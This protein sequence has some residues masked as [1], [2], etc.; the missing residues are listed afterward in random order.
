VHDG[1]VLVMDNELDALFGNLPGWY[2]DR[3]PNLAGYN[4]I[5]AKTARY[6]TPLLKQL[7]RT[8]F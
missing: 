1:K 5:A 4:V 7:K 3:H 6:L 2:E 8:D